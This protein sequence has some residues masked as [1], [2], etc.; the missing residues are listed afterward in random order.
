M[1]KTAL[2][3]G[4]ALLSLASTAASAATYN[5]TETLSP[6]FFSNS[7]APEVVTGSFTGT[8]NGDLIT[9]L[10]NAS[11]FL[12]GVSVV[13]GFTNGG[14]PL[15]G[16]LDIYSFNPGI[17]NWQPGGA[18][19]SFSGNENNFL[20]INLGYQSNS[21]VLN[22]FYDK[23]GVSSPGDSLAYS[24]ALVDTFAPGTGAPG[25]WSVTP[26]VSAVPLPA[27]LPLFGFAVAGFA[28]WGRRRAKKAIA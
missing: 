25:S 22:Y 14:A 26:A 9:N 4:A 17:S 15:L 18:V 12:N 23:S 28:A 1:N 3:A 19:A 7:S 21:Y 10:S 24:A 16:P 6:N 27:A 11:V 2:L 5:F 8:A 13:Q 20:F